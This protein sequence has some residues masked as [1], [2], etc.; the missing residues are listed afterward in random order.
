L[1]IVNCHGGNYSLAN[2]V[3]EANAHGKKMALFPT[4]RD[5]ANAMYFSVNS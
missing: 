2:V 4:G 3:Q 1:V 5:W